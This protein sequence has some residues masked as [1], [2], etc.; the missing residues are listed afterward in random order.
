V[1]IKE[2]TASLRDVPI[3]EIVVAAEGPQKEKKKV[4]RLL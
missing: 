4:S 2:E 1:I 3:V